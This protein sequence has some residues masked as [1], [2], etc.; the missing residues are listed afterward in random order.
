MNRKKIQRQLSAYLDRELNEE[1]KL[2]VER[3]LSGCQE[4]AETFENLQRNS[5]LMSKL[6]QPTPSGIWEG[7][8]S[9]IEEESKDSWKARFAIL[10]REW[11][12]RPIPVVSSAVLIAVFA[13][14]LFV[15]NVDQD[16]L[17]D[18]LDFYLIAHSEQTAV[19]WLM[20]EDSS[21]QES[22]VDT[23]FV[24]SD[25]SQVYLDTYFGH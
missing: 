2:A 16:S 12:L 11:F 14:S 19:F 17:A 5:Q 3:Y 7:V 18:P 8:Q 1:E 4:S 23:N 22:S 24:V 15:L 13:F 10:I 21:S 9:R 6:R 20:G 25:D